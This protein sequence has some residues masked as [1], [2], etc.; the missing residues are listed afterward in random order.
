MTIE[1]ALVR[2]IYHL[3]VADVEA[4]QS[5]ILSN[6]TQAGSVSLYNRVQPE[7][8]MIKLISDR[9]HARFGSVIRV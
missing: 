9:Q 7:E 6:V 3:Y 5:G 1:L 2:V 4:L 8:P